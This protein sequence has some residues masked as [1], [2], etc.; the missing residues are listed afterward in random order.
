MVITLM[1]KAPVHV[2]LLS[3]SLRGLTKKEARGGRAYSQSRRV[4]GGEGAWL[5]E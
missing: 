5:G 1:K 2:G 4:S 3:S